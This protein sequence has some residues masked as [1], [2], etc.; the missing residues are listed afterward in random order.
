MITQVL[1]DVLPPGVLPVYD[2]PHSVI[3]YD[4]QGPSC[5][6]QKAAVLSGGRAFLGSEFDLTLQQAREDLPA[7]MQLADTFFPESVLLFALRAHYDNPDTGERHVMGSMAVF[8]TSWDWAAQLNGIRPEEFLIHCLENL[9]EYRA[10]REEIMQVI[11]EGFGDITMSEA[12]A[13]N[14]VSDINDLMRRVFADAR[15]REEERDLFSTVNGIVSQHGRAEAEARARLLLLSCLNVEQRNEFEA[16]GKFRVHLRDGRCFLIESRSVH[17]VVQLEGERRVRTFCITSLG[18]PLYD[19]L[20]SQKLMLE[21]AT[22]A[23]FAIAN[24]QELNAALI[25]PGVRIETLD[26]QERAA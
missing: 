24:R 10:S 19:V 1:F 12:L 6:D 23:F 17:N 18:L 25:P 20:L 15:A 3:F 8:P 16:T 9:E 2:V 26:G 11:A 22:E 5:W 21:G 4:Y 13:R 14:R 7:M